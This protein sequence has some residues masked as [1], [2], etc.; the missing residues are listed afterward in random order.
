[1]RTDGIVIENGSG[2]ETLLKAGIG[3]VIGA[4]IVRLWDSLT[5]VS[6]AELKTTLEEFTKLQVA[7]L[8]KR[9]S[10]FD[11]TVKEMQSDLSQ[12]REL[13]IAIAAKLNVEVKGK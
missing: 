7:P 1:M 4:A 2:I 5:M 9:Q 10:G 12:T 3:A 13:V 6:R 8:E 11:K